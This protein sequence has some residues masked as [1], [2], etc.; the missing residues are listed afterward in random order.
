M[1]EPPT[2]LLTGATGFIGG[3]IAQ[4]LADEGVKVR[5]LLREDSVLTPLLQ[6]TDRALLRY[7]DLADPDHLENALEG[8][9][10]VI[11][12]AAKVSFLASDAAEMYA[13]NEQGTANLINAAIHKKVK[14][15]VHLSSVAAL[16]RVP[17]KLITLADH[18]Q[19]TAATTVYASSKFAAEREVWRG[20]AEGLSVAV[21]Y[22]ST[23]IG[24]G[25]WLRSGTPR[26]F[27]TAATK[28]FRLLPGG[29]G[30]FVALSDVVEACWY[31]LNSGEEGL[32]MLLNAEN[33]SWQDVLSRISASVNGPPPGYVLSKSQSAL[34]WPLSS[35]AAKI[36]GQPPSLSRDLHRTAQA[37]Y[38]YDGSSFT[39][40]T[41]KEYAD[42][43]SVIAATG[44]RYLEKPIET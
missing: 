17:G 21:L 12:A 6:R 34:L 15:F 36:S 18:W 30:G 28:G 33:L 7:G 1:P 40:K 10:T 14:R 42:I 27:H 26:L 44:L 35:L 24:P 4:K 11:H 5:Y 31:A 19:E 32:R 37:N 43:G 9:N 20:Q 16:Q 8:C 29:S 22:P 25:N 13:V 2:I 39:E 41:G 38:A 3:A 23:V